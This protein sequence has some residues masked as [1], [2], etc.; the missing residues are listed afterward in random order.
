VAARTLLDVTTLIPAIKK[1]VYEASADQPVYNVQTMQQLVSKSIARQRF[2]TLLLVAFAGLALVLA[3][4][5]TYGVI[6]YWTSQRMHEIGIRMALGANRRII[7][8]TIIGPGLRLGLFGIT[9]GISAALI[10]GGILPGFSNL[11]YG[12]GASD[13]LTLVVSSIVLMSTAILA[14]YVPARRAARW[15]PMTALRSE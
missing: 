2:P 1:V 6:S 8:R 3:S 12:I 4:V 14:C 15:N 10:L 11:L 9:I 7:L 5:G 13:P